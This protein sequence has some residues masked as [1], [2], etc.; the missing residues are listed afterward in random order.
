[1]QVRVGCTG[2]EA[3]IVFE[4]LGILGT[5]IHDLLSSSF[6]D[7]ICLFE[8]IWIG[9]RLLLRSR[10][11]VIVNKCGPRLEVLICWS[12]LRVLGSV[13]ALSVLLAFSQC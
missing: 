8:I 6:V 13:V 2:V 11:W 10:R 3:A 9:E 12:L 4:I 1:M 7:E 5:A